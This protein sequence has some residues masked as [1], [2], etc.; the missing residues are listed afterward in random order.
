ML[1]G[2]DDRVVFITFF[3]AITLAALYGGFL[4]GLF[5]TVSAIA[6]AAYL[7][8]GNPFIFD[9]GFDPAV[10]A[11]FIAIS[12]FISWIAYTFRQ[13]DLRLRKNEAVRREDLE[14]L[15]VQRTAELT[16]QIRV[17][18]QVEQALI[19]ALDEVGRHK[20][21]LS[22]ILDVA[23]VGISIAR[24]KTCQVITGNRTAE[25]LLHLPH[26]SNISVR[27]SR[28]M[29]FKVVDEKL[30]VMA[31]DHMPMERAMRG[32]A[33][34]GFEMAHQFND[35]TLRKLYVNA[36]PLR[37]Q[38]GEITGA[39]MAFVDIT[40][41]KD[42]QKN[43]KAALDEAKRSKAEVQAILDVAPVAIC[44]AREP[45]CDVIVN[46]RAAE[47]L[48]HLPRG[49]NSSF[50][51]QGVPCRPVT[52]DLREI[53]HSELPVQRAAK[54]E[55]IRAWE[56]CLRY[57][58]G[59]LVYCYTN[60]EPLR[61][62][63]GN[64]TG[65]V[66]AF[67]DISR[68]KQGEHRLREHKDRLSLAIEAGEMGVWEKNNL[69]QSTWSDE[70]YRI[71]GYEPGS[72]APG[73]ATFCDRLWPEDRPRHQ[74]ML[75]SC[76]STGSDF[77]AEYCL[78]LGDDRTRWIEV[79]GRPSLDDRGKPQRVYGVVLDITERKRA[80]ENLRKSQRQLET[81]VR[82]AP[83]S[84]AMF[85][86]N[87]NYLAY[88]DRW[89]ERNCRSHQSLIGLN[90]YKLHPDIP[91]YWKDIHRQCL[92]GKTLSAD[93]DIWIQPDGS[94]EWLRWAV[95]PWRDENEEIGGLV[96]YTEDITER[97]R[98]V[99]DLRESEARF[100]AA[101]EASLDAFVIYEPV[102]GEKK[103][104][105]LKV[106]Y[107][108]RM[109]AAYCGCVPEEMEGHLISE[110]LPAAKDANGLIENHAKAIISGE[111][112]EYTLH[113]DSHGVSGY[114]RN[115]VVPFGPYVG[116][117]FRDITQ[118]R[119]AER[120]L[121]ESEERARLLEETLTQ[122]VIYRDRKGRVVRANPA[123]EQIL[124]R[125]SEE[126][127]G[128]DFENLKYNPIREDGTPFPVEEHPVWI[129]LKTGKVMSKIVMGLY[130]PRM[131]MVRWISIEAV[132]LF[133]PGESEP[134]EAY[135]IFSDI[136][137]LKQ[138]EQ[139]LRESEKRSRMLEAT[140]TQ[141][142]VYRDRRGKIVR[143][144]PA[145]E[146]ILGR[147]TAE[148]ESYSLDHLK[149][150][151]IRE[152]GT[153][154]PD[155]EQPIAVA[156]KT[157]KTVSNVVLGEFNPRMNM[158]R[159]LIIDSVPLFR[160][161]ETEPYEAYS[162]FS[163][164]TE[165]VEANKALAAAKG[166]AERANLAK[167]K[168]L[169]AASHDLRQPVQ[170]LALLLSALERYVAKRPQA[171][172]T[173]D[174]MKTAVDG[175]SSLLNGI[176][177]ISRLDADMVVPSMDNVDVGRMV[178][179]LAR[180]YGPAAAGKNIDIREVKSSA[181]VWSDS[182][183]LERILRNLIENALRYTPKGR[184]LIG[185]RRRGDRIRID[186]VD[187]G[188]G[189][190]ADKQAKIFEEFYQVRH[191]LYR[192]EQGMGLGLSIVARV[193]HLLGAEVQVSSH[194][195]RGSRFSIILPAA[196]SVTCEQ[197]DSPNLSVSPGGRILVIEDNAVL[198]QGFVLVL[199]TW[200]YSVISA[201]TGEEAL[202]LVESE[203]NRLDGI[204]SDYQL[205]RGLNGI[206][207]IKEIEHRAGR[208]IPAIVITGD[209][210]TEDITETHSSGY[211]VLHKPVRAEDLKACLADI[212]IMEAEKTAITA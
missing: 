109:A 104:I 50:Q 202:E 117:T 166:E 60:A 42:A 86:L 8:E 2:I 18:K 100:R 106:L 211:S 53:P 137:H 6:C 24:D 57:D 61:D 205:G 29:P 209:T 196:E 22:T 92:A 129:A 134:Y 85:D 63:E 46:N 11:V 74:A 77:H 56:S 131:R 130:N 25:E 118:L 184:I 198:R 69:D 160:H 189:I 201:A 97:K 203:A 150:Q 35:G 73:T 27:Q 58:D 157:G 156:L 159:W 127:T 194:L 21:E 135:S 162:I 114:Y 149:T 19:S 82:T 41:L 173:M 3:P 115:L 83:V 9:A 119:H 171:I 165:T 183:L 99:E 204:V 163:D 124:G 206:K 139:A 152:D 37:D 148:L 71:L 128:L 72:V 147:T 48:F 52:E 90:Q 121:R 20:A 199:E 81:F 78:T 93:E 167:S 14:R 30:E 7:W 144:N 161:G 175:L 76:F 207:T 98:M 141:G 17:R 138:A 191:P 143:V 94:K 105:D 103:V 126:M 79:R 182:T 13:M 43:M 145:A 34:R 190:P 16:R 28:T 12:L 51:Q 32:E 212:L 164:V 38:Q 59:S 113:Y 188:I 80:E 186:V 54:G 1:N 168:F 33:V 154:F 15:V 75:Q 120:A 172:K 158:Y 181:R 31:V 200:G 91:E 10:T 67:L 101:Q 47:H 68:I 123:A 170:S 122:G 89:H 64:I 125:K 116:T 197:E 112:Q 174:M 87:M 193:S 23:P 95:A 208:R 185:C 169:A 36:E 142:V 146:R 210:A 65:A 55:S 26:G 66:A 70:L 140:L 40:T 192:G 110:I 177:D 153:P 151:C 195:N 133:H 108:N 44:I 88:S 5:A 111:P 132:P 49:A 102:L 180:E 176:L 96:I 136:T 4:V 187:T 178:A 84:M 62:E 155:D 45:S 39:V 179:F 107:A